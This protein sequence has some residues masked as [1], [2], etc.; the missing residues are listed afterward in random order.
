MSSKYAINI[1]PHGSVYI[2][3]FP[4]SDGYTETYSV[5]VDGSYVTYDSEGKVTNYHAEGDRVE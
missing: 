5:M 4:D 2:D 1:Y 3:L